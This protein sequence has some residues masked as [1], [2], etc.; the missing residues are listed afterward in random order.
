ML[1]A[2]DPR[3]LA[4]KKALYL[5]SGHCVVPS[6]S[7]FEDLLVG[8]WAAIVQRAHVRRKAKETG[9]DEP[10]CSGGMGTQSTCCFRGMGISRSVGSPAFLLPC[11]LDDQT[12]KD[13]VPARGTSDSLLTIESSRVVVSHTRE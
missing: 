9:G 3:N 8:C 2:I 6:S 10:S 12:T 5:R 1:V 4:L 11:N 13:A 7:C